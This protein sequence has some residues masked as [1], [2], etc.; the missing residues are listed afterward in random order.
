MT[1]IEKQVNEVI[2]ANYPVKAEEKSLAQARSEGAMALFG[3]KYGERVRT[4]IV[5]ENG[6]R[7][8]Y[9]LCGGVHVGETA[10]IGPFIIVNEGSVSAGIRRGVAGQVGALLW[11]PPLQREQPSAPAD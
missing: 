1:D 5:G 3:E 7:Y 9:E 4:I 11:S 2:L 10:E 6:K 8:S